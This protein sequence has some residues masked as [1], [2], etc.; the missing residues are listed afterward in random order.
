M[1]EATTLLDSVINELK[2]L[3][4]NQEES[5]SLI[6]ETNSKLSFLNNSVKGLINFVSLISYTIPN[7]IAPD[8]QKQ[9]VKLDNALSSIKNI[10]SN[11]LETIKTINTVFTSNNTSTNNLSEKLITSSIVDNNKQSIIEVTRS[12]TAVSEKNTQSVVETTKQLNAVSEKNTQLVV[13]TTKQ[14]NAVSEKNIQSIESSNQILNTVSEKNTQLIAQSSERTLQTISRSDVKLQNT[15]STITNSSKEF[16]KSLMSSSENSQKNILKQNIIEITRQ[17]LTSI[18][19]SKNSPQIPVEVLEQ[20]VNKIFSKTVNNKFSAINNAKNAVVDVEEVKNVS[21][22]NNVVNTAKPRDTTNRLRD[23]V[24]NAPDQNNTTRN[25][26]RNNDAAVNAPNSITSLMR[27]LLVGVMPKSLIRTYVRRVKFLAAEL[28]KI[29]IPQRD[30]RPFTEPLKNLG[31]SI[32]KFA[33][34][35]WTRSFISIKALKMFSSSFA[36]A[37]NKISSKE[38]TLGLNRLVV[39]S[40]KLGEPLKNISESLTIFSGI[41]WSKVSSSSR[42][43]SNFIKTIAKIPVNSIRGVGDAFSTLSKKINK[44]LSSLTPILE[45]FGQSLNKISNPMIKGAVA[46]GLLG[47]SLIPLAYG[48]KQ[49]AS[50][51][52]ESIGLALAALGGI[53]A[54]TKILERGNKSIIKSAVGLGLLGAALIP[55]A[56][57][58]K[59]FETIKLK[60]IGLAAAALG[61]LALA[62]TALGKN[63]GSIAKGAGVIAL[64]GLSLLPLAIGLKVLEGTNWEILGMAATAIGGLALA[65]AGLGA[66][67]VAALVATGAGVIALLGLSILPLAYSLKKLSEVSGKQLTNLVPVLLNLAGAGIALAVGSAGL[68]LGGLA[69]LP[70]AAGIG[71]LKL[72]I[73]EDGGSLVS[74]F[75]DNLSTFT[76]SFDPTKLLSTAGAIGAL[77]LAIAGFGAAQAVEGLGNLVGKLLRF[78]S[79]SPLEQFQKFADI[80]IN[81]DVSAK[82]I[83][84]LAVGIE[85][86]GKLG[87]S[88]T[89]LDKFP[90]GKLEDLAEEIEGKSIIQVILNGSNAT[91]NIIQDK[92][93]KE[94]ESKITKNVAN[95]TMSNVSYLNESEKNNTQLNIQ[96]NIRPTNILENVPNNLGALLNTSSSSIAIAPTIVVNNTGGNTNNIS[97]SNVNNMTSFPAQIIA[98][99]AMGFI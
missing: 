97:S 75:L 51:K 3:N 17:V 70:L 82:S 61:G 64:L 13:E 86:L 83:K 77:S 98:G 73:G 4:K 90:W 46:I 29:T 94:I 39:L 62:G 18:P 45:N 11:T 33:E 14:L 16:V 67:P 52:L 36:N 71:A 65:A 69:M 60:T 28:N 35:P 44:P 85:A 53:V 25:L 55:L 80:S 88:I 81:L 12:A 96:K 74:S 57:G 15:L 20:T 7:L 84:E 59:V 91:S 9:V 10:A 41:K 58:L 27:N 78:G 99:S 42:I 50:V 1:K 47:A 6:N 23:A 38:N 40:K 89:V 32:L 31:D 48:F 21:T 68:L 54:I 95:A 2:A 76:N 5:S 8:Q 43:F 19:V 63:A 22:T 87:G 37:M 34:L 49:F 26:Q 56:I 66:P 72:A 93:S 24:V 30:L 79:D 92:N